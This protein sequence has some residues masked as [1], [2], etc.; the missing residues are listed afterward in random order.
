MDTP[1][2]GAYGQLPTQRVS[3]VTAPTPCRRK[4]AARRAASR[5]GAH[6][7]RPC[8]RMALRGMEAAR[9]GLPAHVPIYRHVRCK[10]PSHAQYVVGFRSRRAPP[11]CRIVG[12]AWR[13]IVLVAPGANRRCAPALRRCDVRLG[14]TCRG[15]ARPDADD[16]RPANGDA[17][18]GR[19]CTG[20]LRRPGT[21]G[22]RHDPHPSP[23]AAAGAQGRRGSVRCATA[24]RSS[25]AKPPSAPP[26]LQTLRA[27]LQLCL[28]LQP[29]LR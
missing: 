29:R 25:R 27:P 18:A 23:T 9:Y 21:A 13:R 15:N 22:C 4:A 14:R 19:R 8:E 12:R 28:D 2:A 20:C 3:L 1:A 5:D 10:G 16:G 11:A 17:K 6:K 24:C 7:S 26:V